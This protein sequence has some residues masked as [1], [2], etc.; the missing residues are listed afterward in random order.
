M[1]D[2]PFRTSIVKCLPTQE[3]IWVM[4]IVA[5][6]IIEVNTWTFSCFYI[7]LVF[8]H[9]I[10]YEIKL[11]CYFKSSSTTISGVMIIMKSSPLKGPRSTHLYRITRAHN[12]ILTSS[13]VWVTPPGLAHL[14]ALR[15]SSSAA[16]ALVL[17]TVASMMD[18][19]LA[20]AELC[21]SRHA[22]RCSETIALLRQGGKSLEL[23]KKFLN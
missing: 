20:M 23:H 19:C 12:L 6:M 9:L 17:R 14:P 18:P 1:T 13:H 15:G 16:V 5:W 2:L 3:S 7:S 8:S 4:H 21:H 11:N 22:L 10:L